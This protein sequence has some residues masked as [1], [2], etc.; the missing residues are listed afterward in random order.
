MKSPIRVLLQTTI[1]FVEDDWHIGRFSLL[2]DEL[3]SRKDEFG[4]PAF[5]VTPASLLSGIITEWG[6]I[7]PVNVDNV[8]RKIKSRH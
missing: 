2:R 6:I 7:A 1:P 4:N 3:S 5:D 8:Q